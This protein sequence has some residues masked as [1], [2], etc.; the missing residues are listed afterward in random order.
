MTWIKTV[1]VSEDERVRQAAESQRHLYPIEYATPI[2]PTADGESSSIVESH[3][4]IPDALFHAFST[5][6][7]LMSPN[8]PLQRRQHE[9]ITTMVSVINRCHY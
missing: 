3:S 2:H 6:G 4:L 8:L 5:F 7:S 9:M 1:P